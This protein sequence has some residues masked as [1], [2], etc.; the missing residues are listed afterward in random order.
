MGIGLDFL[1]PDSVDDFDSSPEKDESNS[2]VC[3]GCG[4]LDFCFNIW[5]GV[6]FQQF[7]DDC[8]K[9]HDRKRGKYDRNGG[10]K[11]RFCICCFDECGRRRQ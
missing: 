7:V 10:V 5:I 3:T 6:E 2:E 4:S 1:F 11:V 8:D 9:C